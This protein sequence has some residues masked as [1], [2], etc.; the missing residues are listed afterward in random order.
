MCGRFALYSDPLTLARRFQ[1]EPPSD[2]GP[3]F[4]IAPTQPILM[5]R[6]KMMQREF[7]YARWGLVP[8][9]AKEIKTGY[10]MIN[11]R[12]ETVDQRPAFRSAFHR[13]RCLIPADGFYEWQVRSGAKIKQPWF[14]TLKERQPMAL[15][16][17][18]EVWRSP[19]GERLESC[20]IIVTDA[21]ELMKPIHDRMPVI[22]PPDDWKTWLDPGYCDTVA[23]KSLLRP[24]P[25]E[26]MAAWPVGTLVNNPRNDTPSC[27]EAVES[28][29]G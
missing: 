14:V 28:V 13:R 16:G 29:A 5:L 4:N 15:A 18:W 9:W 19:E 12:A 6:E 2:Y 1:A 17:L 3:H 8:H 20:T 26:E 24:Y 25:S 27:I 23:L 10:S 21:N 7:V 22:L 11:A